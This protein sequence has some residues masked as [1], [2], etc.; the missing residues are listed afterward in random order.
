MASPLQTALDAVAPTVDAAF[1]AYE[2][3]KEVVKTW[4]KIVETLSEH[5]SLIW[6]QQILPRFVGV[7]PNNRGGIGVCFQNALNSAAKHCGAGW[8]LARANQGA[9]AVQ[10][11]PGTAR[12]EELLAFNNRIASTQGMPEF[13][14]IFAVSFGS[15]LNNCFL[16]G[17]SARMECANQKLAPTGRLDPSDLGGK[18]PSLRKALEQGLTW[19]IVAEE[20]VERWPSLVPLGQKALNWR[21]EQDQSELEGLLTMH[22]NYALAIGAKKSEQDAW[23][24]AESEAVSNHP[25]WS[26]WAV[27]LAKFAKMTT[28]DQLTELRDMKNAVVKA[29]KTAT[30][31]FG[32][33]GGA[34][35]EKLASLKWPGVLQLHRVR[36]AAFLSN[37][38][39]PLEKGCAFL[40][41]Q[42]VDNKC[43]LVKESDLNKLVAKGFQAAVLQAEGM[44][45]LARDMLAEHNVP[46]A[47]CME[48]LALHDTAIVNHILRKGKQSRQAKEHESLEH[49][50]QPFVDQLSAYVGTPLDNP[51]L[52]NKRILGKRPRQVVATRSS[53]DLAEQQEEEPQSAAASLTTQ[54]MAQLKD[55]AFQMQRPGFTEGCIVKRRG[56]G[57]S[58]DSKDQCT[59]YTLEQLTADGATLMPTGVFE[60]GQPLQLDLEKLKAD[61]A[62]ATAKIQY[63]I[64]SS[65]HSPE[66]SREWIASHTK[67]SIL[68]CLARLSIQNSSYDKIKIYA[69]PFSVR[70]TEA[71]KKGDLVFVPTTTKIEDRDGDTPCT[72]GLDLGK[73]VERPP[74]AFS[75]LSHIVLPGPKSTAKAIV[76][77]FWAVAEPV[78]GQKANMIIENVGVC[79]TTQL[80]VE[81]LLHSHG[82]N[83]YL[84][85]M[86]NTVDLKANAE[87]LCCPWQPKKRPRQ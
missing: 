80:S 25:F 67:G 69:N 11:K 47:K 39:S 74:I 32:Y 13:E 3:D 6:P 87:L 42:M 86:T 30:A 5:S 85:V 51:W 70:T 34:F 8:S 44:M 10:A 29:P 27:S 40:T 14:S 81:G 15:S 19:T 36:G 23:S 35:Y 49:A 18:H 52:P 45:D 61:W 28:T 43:S 50:G 65:L 56:S 64:D 1:A 54:S 4:D 26:G 68:V 38:L 31:N 57:A 16:R 60:N 41:I 63:E 84:P 2:K 76:P 20:V 37:A 24:Y 22:S 83:F 17:V 48:M 75:L 58:K 21:G 72:K 9:F 53:D 12:T 55:A 59:Y 79:E 46:R 73:M 78:E 71:V 7:E 77:P 33:I 62:A 82:F 66:A